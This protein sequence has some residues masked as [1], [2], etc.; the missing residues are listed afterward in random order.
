M[1]SSS[2]FSTTSWLGHTWQRTTRAGPTLCFLI[3]SAQQHLLP[4]LAPPS[5]HFC[6]VARV[7]SMQVIELPGSTRASAGGL[8]VG[9]VNYLSTRMPAEFVAY[10]TGHQLTGIGALFEYLRV[11][12]SVALC[13]H[14]TFAVVFTSLSSFADCK[15]FSC[16]CR[17]VRFPCAEV[18]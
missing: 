11:D 8:R 16:S 12:V 9:A 7:P 18:G 5:R 13:I 3:G 10:L 6:L 2:T 1:T 14:C 17:N 15:A 4:L